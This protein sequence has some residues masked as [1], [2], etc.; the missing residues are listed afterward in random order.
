VLRESPIADHAHIMR[1]V[2]SGEPLYVHDIREEPLTRAERVAVKTRNLVTVVYIP[3]VA[4]DIAEGVLILSSAGKAAE[5]PEDQMNLVRTLANQIAMTV[6]NARLFES[7]VNAQLALVAAYDATIAGWSTA[8]EMRDEG[9]A[10][11]TRR[12]TELAAELAARVGIP[13]SEIPHVR[14]GALLHD[15]GKMVVPDAIL[16]KAAELDEDEWAIM[17]THPDSGRKFLENVEYL[18]PAIDIPYCHHE[19]WDGTGYPRGLAGEQIP[20]AARV[21]AVVDVLDALTSDRSYRPAWTMAKARLHIRE[22]AGKHFDPK[23]V[24]AF[25]AMMD[26]TET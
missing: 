24:D 23:V 7:M 16:H 15:I 2:T 18:G 4:N 12:V 26:A 5:F 20:L 10:G 1:A 13:D 17:H 19:R 22:Q 21:F 3:L 11:H 14:R 8:L 6:M 25:E 9:T